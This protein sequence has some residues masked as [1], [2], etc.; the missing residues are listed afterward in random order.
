MATI[1]ELQPPYHVGYFVGS[2]STQS[3]NRTLSKALLRLA[4]S[5]LVFT[6]IPIGGLPLYNRDLDGHFPPEAREFKQ[7]ISEQD[8]L[9]FITPE[10]N[11]G[12]TAPL[13][14]AIDYLHHEWHYKPVGLVS[15]GGVAAGTR[16]AQMLK[17]V[18]TVLRMTP[19]VETVAIPFVAEFIDEDENLVPNDVMVGA[20]K[21]MFDELARVAEALR[22]LRQDARG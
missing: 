21:A 16:A 2:L 18:L 3:V 14:N 6:E 13:K 9:L 5:E 10:Y 19:V 4:P 7:L 11:H 8:A 1:N 20:A 15:Y 17:Q 12:F 22:P